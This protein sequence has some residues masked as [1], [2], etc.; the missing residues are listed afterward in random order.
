VPE[1]DYRWQDDKVRKWT[2][3][4]LAASGAALLVLVVLGIPYE[5]RWSWLVIPTWITAGATLGL[6][7]G[8]LVTAFYAQKT[9]ASQA[10]QLRA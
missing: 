7:A 9:F 10:D 3:A 8:T 6:F 1:R 5:Q 4:G 2:Y